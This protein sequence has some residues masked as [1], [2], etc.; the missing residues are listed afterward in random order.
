MDAA[1]MQLEE[2]I[3]EATRCCDI[4][5]RDNALEA[6]TA[7]YRVKAFLLSLKQPE[8]DA[9]DISKEPTINAN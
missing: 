9:L 6:L 7:A 3:H 5:I 2:A 1:V 4:L 8:P